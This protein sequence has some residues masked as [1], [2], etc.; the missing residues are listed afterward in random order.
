MTTAQADQAACLS[1]TAANTAMAFLKVGDEVQKYCHP[2]GDNVYTKVKVVDLTLSDNSCG[3]K[4]YQLKLNGKSIDLAYTYVFNNG[5]WENFAFLIGLEDI[6]MVPRIL[7]EFPNA[8]GD[9]ITPDIWMNAEIQTEEKGSVNAVLKLQRST[10]ARGDRVIWG[11][12]YASPADVAWGSE[13]NPELYVKAWFDVSGRI[14]VNFFHVSVPK[15][16]VYSAK[17]NGGTLTGTTTV[18]NRYVRHTYYPDNN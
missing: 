8:N 2:C 18:D 15:I 17:N 7:P 5:K 1:Q 11:Y 12:F 14:D 3:G 4:Y 16:K 6:S 10:T 13:D 9:W